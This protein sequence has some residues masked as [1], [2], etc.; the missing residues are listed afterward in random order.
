MTFETWWQ[1]NK[2][3]YSLVGVSKEIAKA[4]WSDATIY[5]QNSTREQIKELIQ[6]LENEK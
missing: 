3:L 2:N 4:I 1:I 5:A 6:T